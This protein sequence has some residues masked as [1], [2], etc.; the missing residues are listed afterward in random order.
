VDHKEKCFGR[1][2]VHDHLLGRSAYDPHFSLPT[3]V[4]CCEL[5]AAACLKRQ[6]EERH[7]F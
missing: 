1:A 2:I 3:N 4:G 7:L 5:A 6:L